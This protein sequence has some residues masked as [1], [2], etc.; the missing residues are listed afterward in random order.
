MLLLS[1]MQIIFSV[2]GNS[3]FHYLR[4][5]EELLYLNTLNYGLSCKPDVPLFYYFLEKILKIVFVFSSKFF[6][7]FDS[8]G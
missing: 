1:P 4:L 7:P 3:I 5:L 2:Q 8:D 6:Q